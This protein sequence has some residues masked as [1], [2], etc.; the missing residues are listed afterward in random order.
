MLLKRSSTTNRHKYKMEYLKK[1]T[2]IF[3]H[4]VHPPFATDPKSQS[5]F[6]LERNA[7]NTRTVHS[8]HSTIHQESPV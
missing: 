5:E 4:L 1:K 3:N 2:P 6:V 8:N 7:V